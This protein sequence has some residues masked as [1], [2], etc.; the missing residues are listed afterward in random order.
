MKD[1]RKHTKNITFLSL[2][3]ALVIVFTMAVRIPT[4]T[5]GGYTNTGDIIVIFSGLILGRMGGA[6]AGGIGSALA[7]LLGGYPVYVPLTLI[8]KGGEGF[9][10][11]LIGKDMNSDNRFISLFFASLLAGAWMV[12]FYFIGQWFYFSLPTALTTVIG[13]IVQALTGI[14]CALIIYRVIGIKL[15]IIIDRSN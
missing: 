15:K 2:C 11:G 14:I 8:A 5:T 7:D 4:V 13:N 10:A 9:I 3:T 1:K 6:I 12:F